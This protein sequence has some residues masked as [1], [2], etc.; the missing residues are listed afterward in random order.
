MTASVSMPIDE[1][2]LPK[3]VWDKLAAEAKSGAKYE[4]EYR[5]IEDSQKAPKGSLLEELEK[6]GAIG[7][8]AGVRGEEAEREI[9][10]GRSLLKNRE[11]R[12]NKQWRS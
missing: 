12:L 4:V 10:E 9:K 11:E 5:L 7:L 3:A 6:T 2:D 8:W 1:K